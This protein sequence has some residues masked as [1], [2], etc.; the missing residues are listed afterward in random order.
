MLIQPHD[1]K[2]VFNSIK[3]DSST[4]SPGQVLIFAAPEVDAICAARILMVR[5]PLTLTAAPPHGGPRAVLPPISA[6]LSTNARA[7]PTP[8]ATQTSLRNENIDCK[9]TPV[10]G[11]QDVV[12]EFAKEVALEEASVPQVRAPGP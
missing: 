2:R 4:G 9:V 6:P 8:V 12:R 10:S 1:F 5:S 3:S 7:P 11:Y